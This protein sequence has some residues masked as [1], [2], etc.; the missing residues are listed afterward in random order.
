MANSNYKIDSNQ[1][2]DRMAVIESAFDQ[3][4]YRVNSICQLFAGIYTKGYWKGLQCQKFQD[5]ARYVIYPVTVV[6]HTIDK[7]FDEKKE[8]LMKFLMMAV[9]SIEQLEANIKKGLYTGEETAPASSHQPQQAKPVS[10]P[11]E[12]PNNSNNNNNNAGG[13]TNQKPNTQSENTTK[14]ASEKPANEKPA[15]NDTSTSNGKNKYFDVPLTKSEQDIVYERAKAYGL[16]PDIVFAVI[17]KESDFEKD[18]ITY[19]ED[20]D[21]HMGLMQIS[22]KYGVEDWGFSPS[23]YTE[24]YHNV[25]IGCKILAYQLK[26]YNGDYHRALTAYLNGNSAGRTESAY[27]RDVMAKSAKYR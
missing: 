7:E 2:F 4:I 5:Q 14:P 19:S 16:R 20:G 15:N 3:V 21:P 22:K 26:R 10:S 8:Q 9:T 23:R 24:V 27:S 12:K 17:E 18:Q 1:I 25:D 6:S 11:S 13:S